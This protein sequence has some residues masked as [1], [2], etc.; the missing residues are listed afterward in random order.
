MTTF[1]LYSLNEMTAAPF[2]IDCLLRR[3]AVVV[4]VNPIFARSRQMLARLSGWARA[5]RRAH[6]VVELVPDLA[7]YAKWS[8]QLYFRE[9]FSRIEPW[10]DRRYRFAD[11]GKCD[12]FLHGAI[13]AATSNFTY[14]RSFDVYAIER[15]ARAYP[16]ASLSTAGIAADTVE[17]YREISDAPM[18]PARKQSRFLR[19]GMTLVLAA[20]AIA[21]SA[22]TVVRLIGSP[23]PPRQIF[24]MLDALGNRIEEHL[25]DEI[26]DGG[27]VVLMDRRPSGVSGEW[28]LDAQDRCR[29]GEGC[30]GLNDGLRVLGS[31]VRD[32]LAVWQGYWNLPLAHFMA[33]VLLPLKRARWRALFNLY[34]PR[35]FIGRDEYNPD[36][37]L[38]HGEL[39]RIDGISHGWSGAV[40]SAFTRIAPN[41]R[42][43]SFDHYY[44]L[45]EGLFDEYLP[46]WPRDMIMHSVG[47]L[48]FRRNELRMEWP[49]GPAILVA[50][51]I[52][53]DH[54]ECHRMVRVLSQAFP[55]RRILLQIK[56]VEFLSESERASLVRTMTAGCPNVESTEA[57]IYELLEL[58]ACLISDIST[59]VAEAITVGVPTYVADLVDQD[60]CIFR[61]F[62]GL[63]VQ[64][65]EVL[66]ESTAAVLQSPGAYPFEPYRRLMRFDKTIAYD[67]FRG[68][69][70]LS[71]ES[72][73][74]PKLAE[75]APYNYAYTTSTQPDFTAG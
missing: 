28:D 16:S 11:A 72:P 51:R 74:S 62:P 1:R 20:C 75:L 32:I 66:K 17:I 5:S 12:L 21:Y 45:G 8:R 10:Q 67:A 38:R 52:A 43:V 42:Y 25:L 15:M 27:A 46:R 7:P 64:T 71:V 35:H 34:C 26:R 59:L 41:A 70:G 36:H 68:A 65:A 55:D 31:C 9:M 24:A 29:W 49:R 19:A 39:R 18:V 73:Q 60:Y 13:K 33:V 61:E 56:A 44:C 3:D 47:S 48:G 30:F 40:Y 4:S 63:C 6:D 2:V 23:R 69:M 37:I 22:V 50:M 54:P 58:A 57:P 14:D 53:F